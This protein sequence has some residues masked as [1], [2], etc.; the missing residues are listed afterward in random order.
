MNTT[1]P[2]HKPGIIA[3]DLGGEVLLCS[4]E[5]NAIHLL[6]PTAQH[7]REL[8]DG[9]HTVEEMEQAFGRALL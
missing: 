5:A 8:C 3:Q 4:P 6:N 9:A 2:V 7:I 1:R